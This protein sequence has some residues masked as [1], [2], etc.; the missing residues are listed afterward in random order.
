M[1]E[2]KK[3]FYEVMYKYQKCF[4]ETGVMA[5]LNAWAQNKAPLLEL[6]RRHPLWNEEAKAIVFTF[7]EGRGIDHDIVDEFTFA[8][9]DIASEQIRDEERL[10][11]FQTALRAAVSEH[12]ST[13][14]ERILE[15]IRANGGIKCATGQKTS[16]IIGRLCTAFG[17]DKHKQ[18]NAI[19]AQLSDSLNPLHIYKTALLSVHPC[20]FLEM[21]SKSSTWTSCHG[22]KSGSYQAGTLSYMTD[23]VSMIFFTVDSNIKDHFYRAG[24][25]ARQMFFYQGNV[26][27]QSKLYPSDSAE[28]NDLYRSLV[29]RAIATC[30]GVPNRW[31][32][33]K[34]RENVNEYCESGEGSQQYPDY[35]R[36]GNVSLL[37]EMQ[38]YG[39]LV[40]GKPAL[41]VC[42]GKP[43]D[44]RNLK[45]YCE[46]MVVCKEC[47]Q[48][49]PVRHAR[50]TDGAYFCNS[51]L[52]V[53][54]V[55]GETISGTMYPAYNRRGELVEV[56]SNCYQQALEPCSAC[57]VRSLCQIIGSTFCQRA[58]VTA[59]AG[60]GTR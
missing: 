34:K 40:I 49:V 13:L 38:E 60:G 14:P 52:H 51:C 45:C 29:Q 16:R 33:K 19:F 25:R 39:H 53:C 23:D 59:V 8:L 4:S 58:T 20:D 7:D 11:S 43:F 30:L 17:V 46:D 31:L 36:Y 24:R 26:L 48:T 44:E 10:T 22:L 21:S 41:C 9:E 42:C 6:L 28:Q 5:N 35:H 27:F 47:G 55:C 50:F 57:S 56:C 3:E 1:E 32:L 37:K 12:N 2:L 54:A 15:I 18:Y